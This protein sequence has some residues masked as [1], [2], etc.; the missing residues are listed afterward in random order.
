MSQNVDDNSY[1]LHEIVEAGGLTAATLKKH[2]AGIDLI[3]PDDMYT[4][5]NIAVERNDVKAVE[6]LLRHGASAQRGIVHNLRHAIEQGYVAV[7]RRLLTAGADPNDVDADAGGETSLMLSASIG[8]TRMIRLLLEQ[9]ADVERRDAEGK[10]ALEYAQ[11]EKVA[12]VLREAGVPV[13]PKRRAKR[14]K[15]NRY[16]DIDAFRDA[17]RSRN[18][19][20]ALKLIKNGLIN[21]QLDWDRN[22]FPLTIAAGC[23]AGRVVNMLLELGAEPNTGPETFT[24]PIVNAA[25]HGYTKIIESLIKHGAKIEVFDFSKRSTPLGIAIANRHYELAEYLLIVGARKK[26]VTSDGQSAL[27]LLESDQSPEA[28]RLRSRIHQTK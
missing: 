11:G 14:R 23:G 12:Q 19:D 8:N 7:A 25:T 6:L 2:L 17:L 28:N 5:L 24:Y 13:P 15:Q 26:P 1:P 3:H 21:V 22:F 4:P 18:Q 9:G 16:R 20:I 27:D 10:T